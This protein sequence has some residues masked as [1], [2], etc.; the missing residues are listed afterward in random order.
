MM[1]GFFDS[2][3]HTRHSDDSTQTLG[4]LYAAALCRGLLGFA[5]TDHANLSIIEEDNTFEN[6]AASVREAKAARQRFGD[7]VRVLCGVEIS[8]HFDDPAVTRRIL[9]LAD[10]DVV[11]GSVH[12]LEYKGWT[13]FYSKIDFG[14]PF[15]D[16]LLHGYLAAYFEY[17][18]RVAEEADYDILAHMTCPLRYVN[19]KYRRAVTLERHAAAIDEI[20][21]CVIRRGKALEVNTSGIGGMYESLMPDVSIIE[22]YFAL[23]G[24]LVTLGSDAHTPERVGNAFD[25]TAAQLAKIGFTEYCYYERRQVRRVALKWKRWAREVAMRK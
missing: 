5:V 1:R 6:I 21:R 16:E 23:G 19:G 18:L 10:Y 14:A 4:E 20:L 8:E 11:I 15:S 25:A 7:E 17:L 9:E 3:T 22:R 12:R 13:D 24:R 2:H